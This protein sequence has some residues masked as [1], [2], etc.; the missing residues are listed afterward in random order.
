MGQHGLSLSD[1]LARSGI[2]R[3]GLDHGMETMAPARGAGDLE[4]CPGTAERE[5]LAGIGALGQLLL[6]M[7]PPLD[8]HQRQRG[9]TPL[10]GVMLCGPFPVLPTY[11]LERPLATWMLVPEGIEGVI[12]P[13]RPLL[14][15]TDGKG[16]ST[17]LQ[18]MV[19]LAAGDPLAQ[20]RFC[21]LITASFSLSLVLGRQEGTSQFQFSFDP[22]VN[23]QVWQQLQQRVGQARP[24]LA[25]SLL[26][27]ADGFPFVV[28]DYRLVNQFGRLLLV[29]LRRYQTPAPAPLSL[30]AVQWAAA[31]SPSEMQE[32][33]FGATRTP[34]RPSPAAP[35]NAPPPSAANAHPSDAALLKAM[36]HEI[37]TPL[38]TIRT[39]TRSLLKRQDLPEAVQRRL[40]MID[41]ECTQQID[42]FGLIFRA[43]ELETEANP[44]PKSPLSAM[45]LTQ[46]FQTSVPQWQQQASRR[47]LSLEVTFPPELPQVTSDPT[48]LN[49]VLTGLIDRFTHS[50]P[51]HSH[52]TLGV[53][54]AGHQLKLQFRS[55][56]PDTDPADSH[57]LSP[58]QALGQLLM[59]QPET[60]GLSLNLN[61]TKNLFQALGGK[62]IVRQRPQ[63]GEVLTVFLP[64]EVRSL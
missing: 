14:T 16:D 19:P 24:A 8:L 10:A 49:Q 46:L 60:G 4:P 26:S 53:T 63:A 29:Q 13:M 52:I 18:H 34:P 31:E 28:P 9:E 21:L 17:P 48:M 36:A 12:A 23:Q 33:E 43:V 44:Q 57:P 22:H 27:L 55:V 2:D 37:C 5:W 38:T 1:I 64:L 6:Q 54:L 3:C 20:E 51:P 59:F 40:S 58:F 62:L 35:S 11:L 45:S 39:F 41:R 7:P 25:A 56:P 32:A 50:L 42:R 30:A 47:N 15:G 61:A